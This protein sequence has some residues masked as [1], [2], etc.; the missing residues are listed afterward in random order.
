M[1][2]R[3]DVSESWTAEGLAWRSVL[4]RGND[5]RYMS[6]QSG[7]KRQMLPTTR[8]S[9]DRRWTSVARR[10]AP[11]RRKFRRDTSTSS[12][13]LDCAANAASPTYLVDLE[14]LPSRG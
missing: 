5:G 6:M 7:P 10:D 2:I 9:S 11:K 3:H 1:P 4:I 13:R 14:A 8:I 12:L